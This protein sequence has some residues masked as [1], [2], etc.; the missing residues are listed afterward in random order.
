M[1]NP[2]PSLHCEDSWEEALASNRRLFREAD[3]LEDDAYRIIESGMNDP[4]GLARFSEAKALADAQRRAA[5]LDW[6]RIKRERAASKQDG[7]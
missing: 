6:L 1:D 3:R 7:N 5:F 2:Q 4:G